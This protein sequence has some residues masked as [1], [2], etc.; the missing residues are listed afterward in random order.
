[1]VLVLILRIGM[2]KQNAVL[3]PQFHHNGAAIASLIS[4]LIVNG[5]LLHYILSQVRLDLK[6]AFLASTVISA[7]VT[8]MVKI[9]QKQMGSSFGSLCFSVVA[10]VVVYF[11]VLVATRN[12]LILQLIKRKARL[13]L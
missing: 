2:L 12:E 4:E 3:I 13:G 5:I 9:I 11:V 6:K 1:M 10:G 7:S 8:I